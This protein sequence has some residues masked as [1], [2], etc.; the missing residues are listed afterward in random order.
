MRKIK[1]VFLF[2]LMTA[3]L[4][5]QNIDLSKLSPEQLAAYKKY[6]GGNAGAVTNTQQAEVV[7]RNVNNGEEDTDQSQDTQKKASGKANESN[8]ANQNQKSD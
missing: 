3:C 1:F 4:M 2:S 6:K 8:F 7:D 5:A